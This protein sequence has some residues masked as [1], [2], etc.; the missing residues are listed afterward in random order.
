[1]I[2]STRLIIRTFQSGDLLAYERIT[3]EGFGA[4]S[5]AELDSWIQWSVLSEKW[6]TRLHQPPYGDRAITLK[7]TGE[8]IGAVGFVPLLAPFEQIPDLRSPTGNSGKLTPEFGLFWIVAQQHQYQGYA[9]EA[10]QVMI[11]HAFGIL[12]LK[13]IVATTE[14]DNRASQRVMEKLGMTLLRN[15][16]SDPAWFQIVGVKN[17]G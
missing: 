17:N 16:L 15:P 5:A 10:A 9:T 1:M 13:R 8:L 12:Q 6:F 4:E 11:D 3:R 14:Y 7:T 2:E